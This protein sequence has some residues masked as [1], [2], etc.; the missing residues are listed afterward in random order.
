MPRPRHRSLAALL[1]AGLLIATAGLT[2]ARAAKD[3]LGVPWWI[4]V[5]TYTGA[6]SKGIYLFQ[7]KTS[8]NPDI[9]EYVT[10]TARGVV[11][12]TPN[13]T[14]IEIDA[15][16]RVLF[17]VNETDSFEGKK[18]GAV[19]AF[20]IDAATG[21]LALLG[22]RS[23][24]GARPCHLSLDRERKHVA[25]ANCA[26]GSVAILPV[27]PDGKLGAATDVRQHAGKSVHP[28][29]QQGPHAQGVTFSPDN[30]FAFVCDLGL[31]KVMVY[32]FDPRAGKLTPHQPAFTRT[33]AG[34]G[35]RHLVF[36]PDGKFAYLVNELDSTVTAFA[37]DAKAG[38]LKELQTLSTLPGY[39]DGPNRAT[40]IGVHPSGKF[41]FTSN[42]GHNS[43]VL[44]SIDPAAGTLT[45]VED[46]S[47]YG[48]MPLGFGMDTPGR[49]FAVANHDSGSLLILRAPENARVKPGGDVVKLPAAA[50]AAFL[51]PPAR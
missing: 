1:A 4:Y 14:F 9:P 43:I 33:K 25:V 18:S 11:A 51:S 12:E 16:R 19:S 28:Q 24:L 8:E 7:M 50:C 35:P 47:T 38:A 17:A 46:Q 32:R 10:M 26:S 3:E 22:Q 34:A 2:P 45:Y 30:Q 21:K 39:Y 48:T 31:D 13:P 44:F 29:R 42:G 15:R 49:H 41:L 36:R 37:Y 40:A 6:E 27:A 23:S 5:G 20:A